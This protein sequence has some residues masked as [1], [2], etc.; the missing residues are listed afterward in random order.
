MRET[1]RIL[2]IYS[3]DV[4]GACGAL[5]ELGGMVVIHDPSGCNSTYNTFDETRWYDK[6][7]L[8][9]LSG[10]TDRDALLGNDQKLIDDVTQA[11]RQLSPRF[12]ALVSSPIPYLNGTDFEG[13]CR[14]LERELAMPAFF[15][16]TNAMHDYTLGAARALQL[17]ARRLLPKE[18]PAPVERGV[19]LL[20]LTPQDFAHPRAAQKLRQAVEGAGFPVVSSWAMETNLEDLRQAGA[21][22]VSLVVSSTG[23]LAAKELRARFGI[24]YVVGLPV[25]AFAPA[26]FAALEEA[27]ATGEDRFPCVTERC[28][29]EE[30]VL[31][32]EPVVMG[33]LAAAWQK[34]HGEGCRVL[35]TTERLHRDLL[36]PGDLAVHGEEEAQAA[37]QSAKRILGD[38]LYRAVSPRDAEFLE[39]PH[40]AFSGRMYHRNYPDLFDTDALWA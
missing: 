11:A 8:I 29:G 14:L 36:A 17:A 19:I 38:P 24:P 10:L 31:L 39:L 34:A 9:F 25:G 18:R 32:G 33:S 28:P 13:I 3:G 21:A 23:L 6:E 1:N 5:Y 4:S 12:V 40:L 26:V 7:S 2:P 35:C 16:P 15:V 30:T 22:Q 27:I 37:L 20:G